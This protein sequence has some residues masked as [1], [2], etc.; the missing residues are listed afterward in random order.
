[1]ESDTYLSPC[2][3]INS[4]FISDLNL[5]APMLKL[6]DENIGSTLKDIGVDK[7]FLNRTSI[8]Q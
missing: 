7:Q 8:A 5:T 6:P 2:T 4:K 1:M 3:K